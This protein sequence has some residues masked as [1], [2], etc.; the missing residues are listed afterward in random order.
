MDSDVSLCLLPVVVWLNVDIMLNC[1]RPLRKHLVPMSVS[2]EI[3]STFNIVDSID[4]ATAGSVYQL[5]TY[6][7]LMDNFE[8]HNGLFTY[9]DPFWPFLVIFVCWNQFYMKFGLLAD[10]YRVN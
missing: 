7:N 4:S 6:L 2:R 8:L 3:A 10:T 5:E 1:T 9:F